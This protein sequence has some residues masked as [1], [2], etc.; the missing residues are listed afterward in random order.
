M[1]NEI[2]L[3][4]NINRNQHLKP[5][6]R[7]FFLLLI[8]PITLILTNCA[9]IFF[10]VNVRTVGNRASVLAGGTLQFITGGREIIWGV[11]SRNDGTG[12]VAN[13]TEIS[14]NGFLHVDVNEFN[15][16]LY[17]RAESL[18]DGF[19]SVMPIRVVTVAGVN[20]SSV[21]PEAVVGRTLQFRS[22]VIGTN[23]PDNFVTWKVGSNISGSV[24]PR[25]KIIGVICSYYL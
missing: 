20:V 17:I 2:K 19:I 18:R 22:Q 13:E 1:N 10:A 16:I 4:E 5:Q 25:N 21:S 8:I 23:N 11:S 15:A 9:S 7:K 14:R 24:F 6:F 12:P 3:N